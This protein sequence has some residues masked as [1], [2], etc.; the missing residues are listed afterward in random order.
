MNNQLI[1]K[2]IKYSSDTCPPLNFENPL[3]DIGVSQALSKSFVKILQD[4]CENSA[5][6]SNLRQSVLENIRKLCTV[7]PENH[8]RV[9]EDF[10]ELISE[11][12]QNKLK[13][14]PS[15]VDKLLDEFLIKKSLS[16]N[17][18]SR[19][20]CSMSPETIQALLNLDD[21]GSLDVLSKEMIHW[22]AKNEKYY[23]ILKDMWNNNLSKLS[24]ESI[25]NLCIKMKP[26][27]ERI[28]LE[29]S[30]KILES[31]DF[32]L[33][34]IFSINSFENI[35]KTCA[36]S[37]ICFQICVGT[38]NCL[39]MA[40][41]FDDK[42][43]AL[44]QRFVGDVKKN[45]CYISTL[46]PIHLSSAVVLIDIDFTGMPEDIKDKYIQHAI[47]YV[48]NVH[49]QSEND[50]IMLLSHYP[51]WFNIYFQHINEGSA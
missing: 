50:L 51:H 42:I 32:D 29:Q 26:E 1:E 15:T 30:L 27:I 36:K 21:R 44:I 33:D 18:N 3:L 49:K 35:I 45:F 9:T 48:Q 25:D 40:C 39:L 10:A 47:T 34:E 16:D 12:Y 43:L 8:V 28:I 46:Y 37:P 5:V 23:N 6:N 7:E 20:E 38:L 31:K 22:N 41:N 24:K 2:L 11:F 19:F 17:I 13:D 14:S 4:S